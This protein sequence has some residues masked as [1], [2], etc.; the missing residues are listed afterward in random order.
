[1]WPS[2][3]LA[4]AFVGE[5]VMGTIR[6]LAAVVVLLIDALMRALE[7]Y[8]EPSRYRSRITRRIVTADK[9]QRG[10]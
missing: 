10:S 1:M 7:R 4:S 6:F 3:L 9:W 8:S 5:V 2:P